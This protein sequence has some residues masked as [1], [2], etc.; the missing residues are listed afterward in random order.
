MVDF[1]PQTFDNR[2][3]DTSG[4]AHCWAVVRRAC[5]VG[6]IT[7]IVL[8]YGWIQRES[9]NTGYQAAQLRC[10]NEELR[11]KIAELRVEFAALTAPD[12]IE[13]R[14]REMGFIRLDEGVEVAQASPVYFRPGRAMLAENSNPPSRRGD[15]LLRWPLAVGSGF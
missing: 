11:D 3:V 12:S 13:G 4:N 1:H 5:W 7:A 6:M 2:P 9:L 14:A 15:S 8:A 10:D